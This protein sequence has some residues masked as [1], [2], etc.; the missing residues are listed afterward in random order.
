MKSEV[1]KYHKIDESIAIE[2]AIVVCVL[3]NEATPEI[4]SNMPEGVLDKIHPNYDK[5]LY[6]LNWKS[7][8]VVDSFLD[9]LLAEIIEYPH[10]SL[11]YYPQGEVMTPKVDA[12]TFVNG[13]LEKF[14]QRNIQN[15][16]VYSQKKNTDDFYFLLKRFHEQRLYSPQSFNEGCELINREAFENMLPR[17]FAE[18]YFE[19][20]DTTNLFFE[21]K[22]DTS[23]VYAVTSRDLIPLLFYGNDPV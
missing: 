6:S 23:L 21:A 11:F 9:D 20:F 15:N 14:Q 19:I 2:I 3:E 4:I 7:K 8:D 12:F 5:E 18:D 10:S 13:L 16:T 22:E 1:Y 17:E